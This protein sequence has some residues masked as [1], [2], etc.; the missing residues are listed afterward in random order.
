VRVD[1]SPVVA[2]RFEGTPVKN[3]VLRVR[4]SAGGPPGA[5][6]AGARGAAGASG[7]AGVRGD[8][9]VKRTGLEGGP[10]YALGKQV[11]DA[12]DAGGCVLEVDLRPDRT[13]AQLAARL[14][15]RR[16]KD[17]ATT[18]LRR[19]LG[20]EPAAIALLREAG[21][22]ALPAA[23][24]ELAALV[25]AVPVPVVDTLPIDR[26][27]STAGGIAWT[28]VDNTLMLRRLPGTFVAGEMVDWEAPTGGYLLQG[29]FST[30]VA[31]AYGALGW[32]GRRA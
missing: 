29:C 28:E 23:A 5:G 30:G 6:T 1:W 26:A 32:L 4:G 24:D 13:A 12:L 22:G 7:T 11:R 19:A 20:L 3:V 2:E 25:K 16:P 9:M 10:V 15:P 8:L 14:A 31:A 17:S 21:G 27:I 18:W